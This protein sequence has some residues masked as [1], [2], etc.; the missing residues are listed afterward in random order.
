[1][2]PPLKLQPFPVLRLTPV[3]PTTLLL[4]LLVTTKT[5]AKLDIDARRG[6][7]SKA[8]GHLDQV[9]LV[10]VEDGAERVRGVSLEIGAVAVF[11]GL[12]IVNLIPIACHT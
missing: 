9:E 2:L 1:M 3:I 10:D 12:F 8:L 6:R 4:L 5:R 11:R 7:E